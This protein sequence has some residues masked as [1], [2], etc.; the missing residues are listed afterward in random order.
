MRAGRQQIISPPILNKAIPHNPFHLQK[1]RCKSSKRF[2]TSN[3]Q[4]NA[5]RIRKNSESCQVP[6]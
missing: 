5:N 1:A 2:L 3:I 4:D 6:T